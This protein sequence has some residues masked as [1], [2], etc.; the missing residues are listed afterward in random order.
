VQLNDI[1]LSLIVVVTGQTHF[2]ARN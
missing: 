2:T 1:G